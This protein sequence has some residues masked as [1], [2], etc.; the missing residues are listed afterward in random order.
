MDSKADDSITVRVV[1]S[2]RPQDDTP[3]PATSRAPRLRSGL[4]ER[5]FA[6]A[7]E[8]TPSTPVRAGR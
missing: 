2:E 5:R 3:H 4:A 7:L 8:T 1:V 6:E